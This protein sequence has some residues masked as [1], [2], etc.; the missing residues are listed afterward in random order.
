MISRGRQNGSTVAT[1]PPG[2]ERDRR[3]SRAQT[4]TTRACRR[5]RHASRAARGAA[6]HPGTHP[7]SVA[8]LRRSSF[9]S[10][11]A[12]GRP[13]LRFEDI[14]LELTELRLAVQAD[15]GY[16]CAG[17]AR[18]TTLTSRESRRSGAMNRCCRCWAIWYRA[19]VERHAAAGVTRGPT[20]ITG[21]RR[22]P[23]PMTT[24]SRWRCVLFCRDVRR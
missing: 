11:Q 3:A 23:V 20:A 4:A 13:L 10:N 1:R 5:R 16:P 8:G 12:E 15:G 22:I 18:S 24:S 7:A 21:A 6:A 9:R 14:P 17:S 19:A 2:I